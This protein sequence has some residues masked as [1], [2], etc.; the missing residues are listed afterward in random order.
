MCNPLRGLNM[1][2]K[3]SF[4]A[5]AVMVSG[6]VHIAVAVAGTVVGLRINTSHGLENATGAVMDAGLKLS[7]NVDVTASSPYNGRP[8]LPPNQF[9]AD[10]K[11]ARATILSSSF[12]GWDYIFDSAGYLQLTHN[13]MLHVFAYEPRKKQPLNVPPPAAFVTV[14]RIGGLSG[15]GIE[16]GVPTD[17]MNGKGQSTSPSG[18]TAQLAGLIASLKYLHPEWNWFDIKAALRGTASNYPNGYDPQKYGYGAIDFHAANALKE[19]SNLPLFAPA[20]VV[21]KQRDNQIDF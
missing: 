5:L 16:F 20:A 14:N 12:S 4:F 21:R 6:C 15:D 17:Y 3:A 11:K 1:R 19:S 7:T 9:I 2:K 10:A 18:V 8:F 13:E